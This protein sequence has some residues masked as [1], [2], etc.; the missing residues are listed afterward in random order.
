MIKVDK[1]KAFNMLQSA[2]ALSDRIREITLNVNLEHDIDTAEAIL[3]IRGELKRL[4]YIY[5]K[6]L[7]VEND[8]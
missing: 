8:S 4:L 7:E 2:A 6:T 5:D 1:R 3:E